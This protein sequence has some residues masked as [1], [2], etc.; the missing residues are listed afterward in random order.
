M[1][2]RSMRVI[3]DP[4]LIAQAQGSELSAVDLGVGDDQTLADEL[5][6]DGVPVDVGAVPV[7]ALGSLPKERLH[8]L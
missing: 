2:A 3:F 7:S 6:V 8:L 4:V 5:G 1:P